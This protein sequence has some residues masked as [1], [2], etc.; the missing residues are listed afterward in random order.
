M[1]LQSSS[2]LFYP[3]NNFIHRM[4]SVEGMVN[5]PYGW[6]AWFL[7]NSN[8][9]TITFVS[10]SECFSTK[11]FFWIRGFRSSFRRL[12]FRFLKY[13]ICKLVWLFLTYFLKHGFFFALNFFII[14]ESLLKF[15]LFLSLYFRLLLFLFLS[16]RSLLNTF[17]WSLL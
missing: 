11:G 16:Y 4:D 9:T 8:I 15:L 3:V 5:F 17:Y 10:G 12:I 6:F 13:A 7:G 1:V 14:I 2:I